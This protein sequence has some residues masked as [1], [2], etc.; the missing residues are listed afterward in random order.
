MISPAE[1]KPELG[2][3]YVGP[4]PFEPEDRARFFGR[5]REASEIVSLVIAHRVVLLY[6]ESG[7]GKSSLINAGIVPRLV[8]EEGF[9]VLPSARVRGLIPEGIQHQDIANVYVF[10]TLLSWAGDEAD[11]PQLAR[12]SLADYLREAERPTDEDE[13]P[14]PR[15]VIF[16]QFEELFTF[17]PERWRDREDLFSQVRGALEE[18]S[19]LRVIFIMRE[20]YIAQMDPYASLLPENLRTRFRLERMGG[21]AALAAVT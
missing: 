17:Y 19:L 6:A 4:R 8:E 1:A 9:E 3:P 5:D 18:D 10:N 7:A 14:V 2:N 15:V 13:L 20:D 21:E 12:S 16:D 11:P